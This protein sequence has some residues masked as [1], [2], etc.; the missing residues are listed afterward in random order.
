MRRN[1]KLAVA[2]TVVVGLSA[3]ATVTPEVQAY[4]TLSTISVAVDTGVKVL[5]TQIVAGKLTPEQIAKA[6]DAF[7][8]YQLAFA[9]AEAAVKT[10]KA[11]QG[12]A[13]PQDKIDAAKT[14]ANA[15]P[16]VT[17]PEEVK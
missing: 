5:M 3:C 1:L 15:I 14:A 10:W 11:T 2:L 17:V 4:R 9:V 13:F 6:K 16:G 8:K 7:E 12:T